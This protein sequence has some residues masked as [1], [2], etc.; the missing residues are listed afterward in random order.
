M[1]DM[2]KMIIAAMRSL[3]YEKELLFRELPLR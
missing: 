2:V 3:G 1:Q